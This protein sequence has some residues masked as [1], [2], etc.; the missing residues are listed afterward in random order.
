M[1]KIRANFIQ[2]VDKSWHNLHN[3]FYFYIGGNKRDGY[4]IFFQS[5]SEGS[6][7]YDDLYGRYRIG[8][9]LKTLEEA[10]AQLDAVMD[11]LEYQKE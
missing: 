4:K 5:K 1:I 2:S 11:V 6:L 3:I 10:Q 8:V 7:C 9:N